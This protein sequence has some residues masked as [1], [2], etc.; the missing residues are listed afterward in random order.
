MGWKKEHKRYGG[1]EDYM[2]KKQ[3]L[4]KEN[5]SKKSKKISSKI[6]KLVTKIVRGYNKARASKKNKEALK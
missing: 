6:M 3:R 5:Q 4:D 1:G 2:A